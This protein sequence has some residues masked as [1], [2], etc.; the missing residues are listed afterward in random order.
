MKK[1]F[2]LNAILS[3]VI[4][5]FLFMLSGCQPEGGE[6]LPI[7]GEGVEIATSRFENDTAVINDDGLKMKLYGSWDGRAKVKIIIENNSSNS[8]K[9]DFKSSNILDSKG[10]NIKIE[11]VYEDKGNAINTINDGQF[12]AAASGKQKLVIGFPLNLSSSLNEESPR[13]IAVVLAVKRNPKI[14]ELRQY[15]IAFRGIGKKD[16]SEIMEPKE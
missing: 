2:N 9:I 12:T 3:V 8:I 5:F 11:S 10:E 6:L 1:I 14:E 4:I 16:E 7:G 13:I 15:K